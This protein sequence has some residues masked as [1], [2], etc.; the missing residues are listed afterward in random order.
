MPIDW[1]ML[2]V[3]ENVHSKKPPAEL[4]LEPLLLA[5]PQ[6]ARLCSVSVATWHR[7]VAD[8]RTPEPLRPSPGCVRW[9]RSE[10]VAWVEAGCPDR[11]TW[12]A[13]RNTPR[14]NLQGD[15]QLAARAGSLAI[16]NE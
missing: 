14:L 4:N 6:A 3:L 12:Q 5:A 10:I 16:R 11:A 7:W 15:D 8:D 13:M 1:G 2:T 9:R